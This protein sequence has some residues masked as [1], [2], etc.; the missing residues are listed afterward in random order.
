M[1]EWVS[2][3]C[4]FT[5]LQHRNFY[6]TPYRALFL[7]LNLANVKMKHYILDDFAYPLS[8]YPRLITQFSPPSPPQFLLYQLRW[9]ILS[10]LWY[11]SLSRQMSTEEEEGSRVNTGIWDEEI[12]MQMKHRTGRAARWQRSLFTS[13]NTFM[14]INPESCV[15]FG[16]FISEM[17]HSEVWRKSCT[18]VY[19]KW[20]HWMK[21]I[22]MKSA[23]QLMKLKDGA[24]L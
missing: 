11:Q 7:A 12:E 22:L 17:R 10:L 8:I 18:C 23:T 9:G 5:L 24:F 1:K 3:I 16:E 21:W 6:S 20:I 13:V 4:W 2:V 14:T 15:R 19:R